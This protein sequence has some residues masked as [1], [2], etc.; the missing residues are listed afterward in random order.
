MTIG[1]FAVTAG[2][3][4]LVSG[5]LMTLTTGTSTGD[6]T[7]RTDASTGNT[8]SDSGTH[9]ALGTLTTTSGKIDASNTKGGMT[10]ATLKAVTKIRLDAA[11]AW[12]NGQAINGTAMYVSNGD[13]D[14]YAQTGGILVNTVSGK[15][16]SKVK[17]GAGSIKISSITGFSP[18]SLL[19]LTASG[20]TVSAPR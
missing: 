11:K 18:T 19:G 9:M 17:T 8:V 6:I 14:V 16:A 12:S 2:Y 15:T 7:L 13:L 10:F 20:G 4:N 5:G 3:A 1:T